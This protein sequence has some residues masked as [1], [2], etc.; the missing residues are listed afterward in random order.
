MSEQA[1]TS[2]TS[3]SA[4]ALEAF[5]TLPADST[6]DTDEAHKAREGQ[7][8]TARPPVTGGDLLSESSYFELAV[9]IS[10]RL[11]D[12]TAFEYREAV[13]K[14]SAD[15]Y[16]LDEASELVD[17]ATEVMMRRVSRGS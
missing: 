3:E 14:K 15:D 16:D 4:R 2:P 6:Y 12:G 11:P 17:V 5:E 13:E 8:D 7:W 10:V 1:G 9:E